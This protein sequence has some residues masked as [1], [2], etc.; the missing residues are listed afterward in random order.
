MD[1]SVALE[2]AE[3]VLLW[4]SKAPLQDCSYIPLALL[5]NEYL[6][7]F[8]TCWKQNVYLVVQHIYIYS[9]KKMNHCK[10][11]ILSFL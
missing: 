3:N 8:A 6:N 2:E 11:A 7:D 10:Q 9:F 5:L 1:K 4:T